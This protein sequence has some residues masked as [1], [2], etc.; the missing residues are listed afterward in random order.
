MKA[1]IFK[2][3]FNYAF[4]SRM[5]RWHIN[6][7][8]FGRGRPVSAGVY[9][10]D[11]CNS[12]CIMCNVWKKEK[13]STYPWIYQKR[14]ID[15]LAEAG[16][17]YYSISGGEPTTVKDLPERLSYAAKKIP[18]VRL[19][20]NGLIMTP[21]LARSLNGSGIKEI[22]ISIDGSDE[23]HNLLRGRPDASEKVWKSLELI[24]TYAPRI[25]IVIN[26]V[27]TPYNLEGLRE[28]NRRLQKF[29]RVYQKYLPLTFHEAFGTKDLKSLPI[30]LEPATQTE[31]EKFLNEAK[32]NPRVVNSPIFLEKAKL[33]FRGI[34]NILPEQKRCLYPYHAIEFDPEGFAYPCRT[35]MNFKNGIPPGS[36][37]L[38]FFKSTDYKKLQ[39]KLESCTRCNG[40][41]ML[42]YYEPRLNFP[43]HNLLYYKF[44]Y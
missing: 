36:N 11:V 41:M 39:K 34:Y 44:R 37:L 28:V 22:G 18:Y 13:P 24:C 25:H 12:R 29:P 32:S 10:T 31:I 33:F 7:Y 15:A 8:L 9:I 20:T 35:G 5:V 19:T 26:S 3:H 1:L 42:C 40:S 30:N 17:F 23:Y 16:C 14:A 2:E 6:Y 21:E 27:I 43:L 4:L 38:E